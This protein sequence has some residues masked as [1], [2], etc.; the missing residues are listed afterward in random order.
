[1]RRT[2]EDDH[3]PDEDETESWP[4]DEAEITC[5]HCAAPVVIALDPSGGANQEYVEDC[6]VCCRP[7]LVQVH[8]AGGSVDVT[9]EAVS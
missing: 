1:M 7:W 3:T 4:V 9:V 2:N 5:P 6:E 8:Y